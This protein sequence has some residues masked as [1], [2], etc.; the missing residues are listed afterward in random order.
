MEQPDFEN[1]YKI[2]DNYPEKKREIQEWEK[3]FRRVAVI[4]NLYEH[5]AIQKL[6]AMLNRWI[7]ECNNKL[8]EDKKLPAETLEDFM[9]RL[10]GYFI[11]R[12]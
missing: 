8:R 7:E 11:E 6:T 5:A 2:F 10:D 9:R 12:N 3:E 1:I 4:N